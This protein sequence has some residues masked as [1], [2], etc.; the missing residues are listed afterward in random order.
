VVGVEEFLPGFAV[1]VKHIGEGIKGMHLG[2]RH[3]VANQRDAKN[4][5]EEKPNAPKRRK[6]R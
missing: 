1:Y 5:K 2:E 6:R 3:K 4:A